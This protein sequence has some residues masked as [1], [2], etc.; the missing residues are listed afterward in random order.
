MMYKTNAAEPVAAVAGYTTTRL[1]YG[2]VLL[3]GVNTQAL[4][5][6]NC[7]SSDTRYIMVSGATTTD[8]N[9]FYCAPT[10]IHY[11]ESRVVELIPQTSSTLLRVETPTADW[12]ATFPAATSKF[13]VY[14]YGF[15]C[16]NNTTYDAYLESNLNNLFHEVTTTMDL[17][18]LSITV[19]T[20]LTTGYTSDC[21]ITGGHLK[22]GVALI[23]G[24]VNDLITWEILDA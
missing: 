15:S 13:L 19:D 11:Y 23:T 12:M 21:K 1:N 6:S 8:E 16:V 20:V 4:V 18:S 10:D 3:D 9:A 2:Q 14:L 5:T 17:G 22:L 24:S 7:I